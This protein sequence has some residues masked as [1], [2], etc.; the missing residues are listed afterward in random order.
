MSNGD[1]LYLAMVGAFVVYSGLLA[2]GMVVAAE[3]PA[4]FAPKLAGN[5]QASA[6]KAA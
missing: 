4:G 6:K 2:Y 3:R 1:I 5:D